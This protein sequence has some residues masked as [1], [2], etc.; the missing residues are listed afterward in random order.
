MRSFILYTFRYAVVCQNDQ[1]HDQKERFY[2]LFSSKHLKSAISFLFAALL[3]LS[4][5]SISFAEA[6]PQDA[7]GQTESDIAPHIDPTRQKSK[8]FIIQY[9]DTST[10]DLQAQLTV[11]VTGV[12]SQSD[13]I[14]QI[15]SVDCQLTGP[16]SSS[17][18]YRVWEGDTI[19]TCLVTVTCNN[20]V[21][22][23]HQFMIHTNGNIQRVDP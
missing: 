6:V 18:K 21:R 23:N 20:L 16:L 22:G 19:N 13:G 9:C 14:A 2:M 17:F 12:Y 4:L 10:G 11:T 1:R 7:P 3:I 8:T 5:A 15:L